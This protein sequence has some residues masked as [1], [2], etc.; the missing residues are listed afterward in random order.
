M[1]IE[2]II[3]P[4]FLILAGLYS[5]FRIPV[6]VARG[7]AEGRI[8]PDRKNIIRWIKIVGYADLALGAVMLIATLAGGAR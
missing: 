3:T 8:S 7:I 6:L 2:Q 1:H 4:V 5:V